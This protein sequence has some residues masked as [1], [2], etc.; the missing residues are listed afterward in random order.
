MRDIINHINE[1]K[2]ELDKL[3]PLKSADQQRLDKKI[4]LELNYNSNHIE[5]NT[6]TYGETEL[7][8]IFDQTRGNHDFR[9]YEEMKGHDLALKLIQDLAPDKER[10]LTESFIR[11]INRVILK[12]AFY[13]EAVT[14]DGQATRR[15]IRIGE[16]KSFPNSVR[17]QNGEM[18]NYASPSETPV[19]MHDLIDWYGNA[20]A[21]S[22]LHPVEVAAEFHYRFVC[23]HPFDDGNGRISRLLMNYHLLKNDLPPVIIKSDD[24]KNY[25]FALHEADTGN[26]EA[27]KIYISDQLVWSL[28]IYLK[29]ARGE[30]VDE[31]KDW[32]K[33][34]TLLNKVGD[35]GNMLQKTKS[36]FSFTDLL[37][38]F[39]LPFLNTIFNK[40]HLI[41]GTFVNHSVYL[42]INN[43]YQIAKGESFD[44]IE[45]SIFLLRE[46]KITS[47]GLNISYQ[48]NGFKANGVNSFS[49]AFDFQ[50][51]FDEF[52]YSL[53][54]L[55]PVPINITKPYHKNLTIEDENLLAGAI[56]DYILLKRE[57]L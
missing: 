4:R 46:T 7:L 5:G 9:E 13:K 18:F 24:K 54:L 16:Y 38:T 3:K 52:S 37:E 57:S 8:L 45:E 12:E 29:A 11:Q 36:S 15:L 27:F 35:P 43:N 34:I 10:D 44:Q 56:T 19:M 6:L 28:D 33:K 21:N 32:E 50:F 39:A 22:D 40:W 1:L 14:P 30:S 55:L 2:A 26:V 42:T 47:A 25:L 48:L 23:I 41:N 49:V 17:L 53:T 20:A 51:S 31:P